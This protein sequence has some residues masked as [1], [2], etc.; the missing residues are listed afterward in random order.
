MSIGL[1][2]LCS[3]LCLY[4][5]LFVL[6]FIE[7][8][9]TPHEASEVCL[10]SNM[11]LLIR[12]P[13]FAIIHNSYCHRQGMMGTQSCPMV[14]LYTDRKIEARGR[15]AGRQNSEASKFK[16][17]FEMREDYIYT[18]YRIELQKGRIRPNCQ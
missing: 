1:I 8:C 4:I 5:L 17:D 3:A 6:S 10:Q 9:T 13:L 7:G 15:Q 2:L 12:Q 14:D 18:I 16:I 11:K